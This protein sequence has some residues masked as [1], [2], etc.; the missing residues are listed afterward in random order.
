MGRRSKK[1]SGVEG[2]GSDGELRTVLKG[3]FM[4]KYPPGKHFD[5]LSDLYT[6][7]L[8]MVVDVSS[9]MTP[10]L[11]K[12]ATGGARQLLA[13][14]VEESYT[15]GVVSFSSTAQ[16]VLSLTTDLKKVDRSLNRLKGY[17]GTDMSQGIKL[18]HQILGP[19]R[20]ERVM[21]IFSDGATNRESA[22][23]A[24]QAAKDDDILILASLTGSADTNLMSEIVSDGQ[25]VNLVDPGQIK[26][27]I[28]GLTASLRSNW[29]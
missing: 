8:L 21:A 19:R 13:A 7:K 10:G 12:E 4:T 16:I 20:G 24:A 17:G 14:A 29:S 22:L 28:A 18:A 6:G 3:H 25:T 1:W 9:S 26:S 15:A 11:M 23:Q 5:A 2:L 27:D